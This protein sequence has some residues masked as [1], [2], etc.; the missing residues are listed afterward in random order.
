MSLSEKIDRV[1]RYILH[2][3][4]GE[5]TLEVLSGVAALSKYHFHR[6]FLAG[7]GMTLYRFI[8][9]SRLRRASFQLAFTDARVIDIALDAGFESPEAFARA[10]KKTFGQSPSQFRK[11]PEWSVWSSALAHLDQKGEKV[12]DVRIVHFEETKVAVLEHRGSPD[13]VMESVSRF[14]RWRKETGFSPV[15][16]SSSFGIPYGDPDVTPGEDFRFDICGSITHDVPANE[17]GVRD[18]VIP[19]ARCAV[20]RH[21]GSLD[22]VADSVYYMYR[23]WLPKSGEE[24]ADYPCYFHYLNLVPDVNE[25][26][27]Q[28][29]IYLP[30]K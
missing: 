7:T 30:L 21:A 22:S 5:L 10:F 13:L 2:N 8:Q 15:R 19:A 23:E 28:T 6:V 16:T 4:D 12:M 20:L 29:D 18:G 1:C 25:C 27:L 3:P 26:D 14:I 9:L 17:Y 11:K 24:P